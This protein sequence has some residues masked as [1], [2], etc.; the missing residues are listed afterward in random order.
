MMCYTDEKNQSSAAS[1]NSGAYSVQ[2]NVTLPLAV[3]GLRTLRGLRIRIRA[4]Q[5][6]AGKL[7]SVV[8]GGAPWHKFDAKA[9]TI[10]F[11]AADLTNRSVEWLQD[12]HAKFV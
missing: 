7:S 6:L 4:P 12:V 9:E 11:D 8:V 2:V 3:T 1:S 10:N 5:L